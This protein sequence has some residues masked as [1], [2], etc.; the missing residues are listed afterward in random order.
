MKAVRRFKETLFALVHLLG[1]G[2]ARGTEITS[3]QC[4]N[5]TKGVGHRGVFVDAGLV[6][7]MATYYKG[8]DLSKKVKAIHRYVP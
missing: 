1:G 7:F 2:P 5:S 3:I 8:Y 4:K 6:S